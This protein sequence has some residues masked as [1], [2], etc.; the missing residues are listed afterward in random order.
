MKTDNW[1]YLKLKE[2]P[3]DVRINNNLKPETKNRLDCILF[4]GKGLRGFDFFS[5]N[6]GQLFFY[7]SPAKDIIK[8]DLK[9]KAVWM[10]TSR[11]VNISS[12]YIDIP[13]HPQYAYG[14]PPY[15]QMLGS[16]KDKPNPFYLY[17][18]DL[19]L[20]LINSDYSE[21]EII[22]IPEQKNLW[23]TYYFKLIH[24]EFSEQI[25]LLKKDSKPFFDYGL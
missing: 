13:E 6:K 18:N 16:K 5:N 10:L 23:N 25:E 19:Y 4:N 22:I 9:R 12:M 20:F 21:I 17:R 15:S 14:N 11:N 7:K 1:I 8:S 24:G 3:I 2:L